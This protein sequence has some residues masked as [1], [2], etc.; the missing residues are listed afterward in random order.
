[1]LINK[2]LRLKVKIKYLFPFTLLAFLGPGLISAIAG[3]DAGGIAT[4]SV[5][6][7]R[8]GYGFL[9]VIIISYIGLAVVQ[10]M[11]GRLGAVTGK[12]FSD[13]VR[14][15]FSLKSTVLMMVVL[16]LANA[17]IIISEFVGIAAGFELLGISKFISVPLSAILMWLLILKGDYGKVEKFFIAMSVVFFGYVITTFLAKP[18]WSNV[19]TQTFTVSFSLD[20]YYLSLFLATIGTTIAPFMQIYTQST[21][22]EKRVTTLNYHLQKIDILLGVALAGIIAFFIVVATGTTLHPQGITVETAAEAAT[23]FQPFAGYLSKALFGIG[24]IGASLLAAGV[25]PIST[26]FAISEAFGWESGVGRKFAEAPL[27]YALFTLLLVIGALVTLIPSTSLINVLVSLQILNALFLPFELFFIMKLTNSKEVMG[28]YK[29][30][31]LSNSLGY[32]TTVGTSFAALAFLAITI[33]Q[34]LHI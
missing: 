3:N 22:V 31:V 26:A 1:M 33:L 11:S 16:L 24:L 25:I 4:Y 28:T 19:F 13:L 23:A 29:N 30:G 6:G 9:W 7:A 34:L 15:N 8:Y 12:G 32:L 14:E 10:E 20:Y 21:I 27:F 17:G 18:D 2:F 5:L